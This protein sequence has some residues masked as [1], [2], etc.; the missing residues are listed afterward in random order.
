MSTDRVSSAYLQASLDCVVLADASGLVVEFNPAAERTFGYTREEALGRTLSE[1]IVP[2][3]LRAAHESAFDRFA[4]T[5]EGQLFGR[6]LELTGMR[7]D[8]SEFP[9]ELTLSR[10]E[11]EPL[12]VCGALRDLSEAKK[13]EH[14]LRRVIEEQA[15]L[16][17]VATLVAG[18]S[19]P[20]EVFAAVA[21]EVARLLDMPIVQMSRYVSD[22]TVSVVAAWGEQ[23]L[24]PGSSWPLDGPTLSA[25]VL[26]TGRPARIDDY[27]DLPGT[28][29]ELIR[30][31]GI[32]S[33]VGAPLMVNGELWGVIMALSTDDRPLGAGIEARLL[34]FT[35]LVGTA[36][37]NADAR[38]D[39]E[40]LADEQAALRRVAV[41]VAEGS[42]PEDVFAAVAEQ[43]GTLLNVPAISMV[44]FEPEG[45]SMAIAVWGD[46]NPFGVGATFEPWPGVMLQ[47]RE[48]GRPARLEDYA[49]ST[50]P[51]TARLQAA[52]I[53]SGVGVP[54]IVDGRIWGTTIALATGGASL[55]D[56]IEER[57]AS[58][59]DLV[60]TAI[61]NTQARDELR[62]LADEQ[63]ALRRVATLVAEGD[64]PQDILAAVAEEIAHVLGV[65][66]VGTYRYESD[67]TAT[68]VAGWG[69]PLYPIGS[70]LSLEG[71]SILA[72][73]LQTRRPASIDDYS[74][75]EG[76]VARTAR[77]AG[78]RWAVGVPIV[79]EGRLWGA[80]TAASTESAPTPALT[81]ARLTAFTELVATAISNTQVSDDLRRLAD[82]QGALRRVAT[83][84]AQGAEGRGVFDAVCEETGRLLAATSVNLAQFTPDGFNLT[85]AGWSL[86]DTHVPAGT[87]LPLDG[88][89][90]NV[91]VW[92]QGTPGRFETY[93]GASGELAALIR[94]RGIRSEVGAPVIVA[95]DVWGA[96]FAGWDT[97]EPPPAGIEFRLASFAEL[98]GTAVANTQSRDD[99][100]R[101][102]DEQAA[103][104]RVATLVAEGAPPPQVFAA[105]AREVAEV[106]GL[107]LV[108]MARFDPDGWVTVIGSAG[109][110]PLRTGT[111]WPTD[112]PRGSVVL[113]D[114]RRPIRIEYT[115]DLPGT[116]AE[117]LRSIGVRWAL[118]VPI[119]VDGRIWGSIG[120][121]AVGEQPPPADVEER[122]LGFTELVA[123]AVSN[124]TNYAQ[125]IASRARI[126]AAGDEARR[127]IERD[128]HD[129]TQQQLVSI[130]LDL[131]GLKGSLPAG[132][133]AARAEVD[134]LQ[135]KLVVVTE[136][137]R[138]ISRGLHPA[139][140]SHA[141]LAPALRS[142]ARR[143]LVPVELDLDVDRRLPQS[144]EIATYFVVSEAL[145]NAA[146]HADAS[147]LKI[148]VGI[149]G[150]RLRAVIVDDGKGGAQPG[151]GSGLTGLIDRVEAL[152]GRLSVASPRGHGT[153]ISIELGLGSA[154]A[155]T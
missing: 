143:S 10:V 60:A 111:R 13:S 76:D 17:R 155:D 123:T 151:A 41:L 92:K 55:P 149:E 8:G 120:V 16:R 114:T 48:T 56:G 150:D 57:L 35:E 89:T 68:V 64:E 146:K 139:L 29:P 22:Q 131:K 152:G 103:L 26:K 19:E 118:G 105:V 70:Q 91:A 66:L 107:P 147:G 97:G 40:R 84:V 37:A 52:G 3:S 98:V 140:L 46:G 30:Q 106:S 116:V 82:E 87:R 9:L 18:A 45:T 42:P 83:L 47:V 58:F 145:A 15:A 1:L 25:R 113:R 14:D 134:R 127:R 144:I 126:V 54:I 74:D 5:R 80:M 81:E 38:A 137:I 39:L 88:D 75:L 2:P 104:R 153:T 90:I 95:G 53:H 96:L 94:E 154:V 78:V 34:D 50:G 63:G 102:A 99:L 6:R 61:S 100:R 12:L 33:G 117:A 21:E 23:P 128:L 132:S 119:I 71:Q 130:G 31:A 44:R 115:D 86:R 122:L 27:S 59:T 93:E 138:E 110:H 43:V 7:A 72:S 20:A 51:T 124:A 77:D 141:G 136:D 65:P 32:R 109:D 121:A 135:D 133:D 67:G 125:L 85:M 28:I 24:P 36:I 108:E 129:G 101:L 112:N 79:I 142:L 148:S 62:L 73:V 4:K 49:Y 69:E 11:G